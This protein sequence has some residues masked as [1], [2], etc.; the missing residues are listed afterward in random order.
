MIPLAAVPLTVVAVGSAAAGALPSPPPPPQPLRTKTVAKVIPV[1]LFMFRLA[2][3]VK[4]KVKKM[5]VEL[6]GQ[7]GCSLW[8]KRNE[9]LQT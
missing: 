2:G 4:K 8:G 6:V 7:S 5:V 1:I 3:K 9:V